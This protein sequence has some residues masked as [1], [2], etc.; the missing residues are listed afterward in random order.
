LKLIGGIPRHQY[1]YVDTTHTHKKPC[2]WLPVLWFGIVSFPGRAWGLNVMFETGAIYRNLPPHSI[3]FSNTCD[4]PWTIKDAQTWDCY[5][6]D[7]SCLEYEYLSSL[8]CK[9]LANKKEHMGQYLFTVAP[10]GDAFSSYPEQA[11]EFSFIRLENDR[12]TIQPTNHLIF[13]ERSFTT[14]DAMEFPRDMVRQTTIW[15]CE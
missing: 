6:T 9:V 8:D 15:S 1:V 11:K 5:G 13:R 2:G 7:F 3:A 10:I 4:A 12:L 14:N